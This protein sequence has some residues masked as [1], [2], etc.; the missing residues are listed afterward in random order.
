M[1][2]AALNHRCGNDH[3]RSKDRRLCQLLHR[4]RTDAI[5]GHTP[6]PAEETRRWSRS[7]RPV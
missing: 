4:P 2:C 7:G 6:I 3:W 1:Q 5:N